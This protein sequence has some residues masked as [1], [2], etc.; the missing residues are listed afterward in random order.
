MACSE[1]EPNPGDD[2]GGDQHAHAHQEHGGD[3]LGG[4]HQDVVQLLLGLPV[5]HGD[6]LS[7]VREGPPCGNKGG[8]DEGGV[9]WQKDRPPLHRR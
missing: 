2:G 4:D 5:N 8:R 9:R 7:G 6:H 1:Q 3:G